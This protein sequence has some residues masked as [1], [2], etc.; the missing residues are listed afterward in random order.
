MNV[1]KCLNSKNSE[2]IMKKSKNRFFGFFFFTLNTHQIR[3]SV[4]L[5]KSK[6]FAKLNGKFFWGFSKMFCLISPGEILN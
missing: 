1:F 6:N 5:S 4:C 2:K 3:F